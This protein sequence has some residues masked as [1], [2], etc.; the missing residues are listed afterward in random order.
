VQASGPVD[1]RWDPSRLDQVLT[2]LLS[3]ALKFGAGNP[4]EVTIGED[5]GM[6][7]LQVVDHGIG[8]PP[9]EHGR[10]FE[11]FARAVA[12]DNYGGLGLGLYICRTIV[13]A[14]GGTIRV[15]S[16]PGRG[17]TFTVALPVGLSRATPAAAP[18]G[19]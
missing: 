17:A 4:V 5:G 11:R 1:G 6:A 15:E 13:E 18:A 12:V 16:E 14:H 10:I 7:R 19:P 8:I 3:N 2:N 9:A